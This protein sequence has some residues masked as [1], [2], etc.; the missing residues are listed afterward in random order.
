MA[1][2][3]LSSLSSAKQNLDYQTFKEDREV[4]T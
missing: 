2:E 3:G 1:A 4:E